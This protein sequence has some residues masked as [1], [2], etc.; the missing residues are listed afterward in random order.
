MNQYPILTAH[1]FIAQGTS[2]A[3]VA[4]IARY[5]DE[6]GNPNAARVRQVAEAVA[7]ITG[8]QLYGKRGYYVPSVKRMRHANNNRRV[9][10]AA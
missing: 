2:A 7:A 9:R 10:R 5:L 8:T 4:S 1:E 6:A 3:A